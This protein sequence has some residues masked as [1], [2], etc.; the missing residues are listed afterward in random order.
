MSDGKGNLSNYRGRGFPHCFPSKYVPDVI[1]CILALK[2][3]STI[4]KLW[5]S[6][7]WP[8][9]MLN[10]VLVSPTFLLVV[11]AYRLVM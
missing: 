4:N 6:S 5:C 9:H 3:F 10:S 11:P 1:C 2:D 8:S 7:L